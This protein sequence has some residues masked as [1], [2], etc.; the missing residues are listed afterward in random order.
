MIFATTGTSSAPFGRMMEALAAL[1]P[2]QLHVQYGPSAPPPCAGAY[3]YLPFNRTVEL[4]ERADVVVSHAGVG[5][6]MCAMHAGHTPIVFPRLKRYGE[7][8]DDHQAELAEALADR[9]TV[10]VA[11]TPEDLVT[12]INSASARGEAHSLALG[13]LGDAVRAAI[14]GQGHPSFVHNDRVGR[15]AGLVRGKLRRPIP[16]PRSLP[17]Y[18]PAGAGGESA[19]ASET[20]TELVAAGSPQGGVRGGGRTPT[21]A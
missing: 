2:D 8:V 11:W 15:R 12:A 18:G 21:A 16:G 13:P 1:P 10:V 6:I 20:D 17:T 19:P 14:H 4:I 9:G 5:S 7:T 3:D